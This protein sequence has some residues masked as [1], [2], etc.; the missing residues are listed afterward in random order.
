[1]ALNKLLKSNE[2][3]S[4]DKNRVEDKPDESKCLGFHERQARLV[5]SIAIFGA[6]SMVLKWLVRFYN[7]INKDLYTNGI[8]YNV[9][10]RFPIIAV[11]IYGIFLVVFLAKYCM[12]EYMTFS[13]NMNDMYKVADEKYREFIIYGMG[14]GGLCGLYSIISVIVAVSCEKFNILNVLGEV[15]TTII[16]VVIVI[17]ATVKLYQGYKKKLSTS[18]EYRRILENIDK[19]YIIFWYWIFVLTICTLSLTVWDDYFKGQV[20]FNDTK[21]S[22]N[23]VFENQ[24]PNPVYM[25]VRGPSDTLIDKIIIE[26]ENFKKASIEC[27]REEKKEQ[28]IC[29][30]DENYY[31][32]VYEYNLPLN[33]CMDDKVYCVSILL[34]KDYI[35]GVKHYRIENEFVYNKDKIKFVQENFEIK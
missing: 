5:A 28:Q 1:M 20:I 13:E 9:L 22:I 12:A 2:R 34:D 32:Y 23:I 21:Q 4:Q 7:F 29:N 19:P 8:F 6:C 31:K 24:V 18:R 27:N 15:V 30:L 11:I 25:E 10:E 33:S 35:G 17:I 26:K 16:T 3:N 14:L